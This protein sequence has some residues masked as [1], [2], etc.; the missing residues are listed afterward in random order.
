[1]GQIQQNTCLGRA[2]GTGRSLDM[3]QAQ[4]LVV[5]C[6]HRRR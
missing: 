4:A 2:T 5:T 1:M 6:I 3:P